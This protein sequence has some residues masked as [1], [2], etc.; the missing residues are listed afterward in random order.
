VEEILEKIF[1]ALNLLAVHVLAIREDQEARGCT[2][3]N[4]AILAVLC[5]LHVHGP[6]CIIEGGATIAVGKFGDLILHIDDVSNSHFCRI[7][8]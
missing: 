2:Q 3:R 8:L 1:K 6:D 7:D 5:Y 4:A